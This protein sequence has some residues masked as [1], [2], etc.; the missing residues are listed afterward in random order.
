MYSVVLAIWLDELLALPL[1][2]LA[3]A[4]DVVHAIIVRAPQ[5][6]VHAVPARGTTGCTRSIKLAQG[7]SALMLN[8]HLKLYSH[9][10]R[11]IEPMSSAARCSAA[12]SVTGDAQGIMTTVRQ[13][14]RAAPPAGANSTFMRDVTVAGLTCFDL[15]P[16]RTRCS[17]W[18]IGTAS[19]L[20][21]APHKCLVIRRRCD[22]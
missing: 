5:Q 11:M 10:C 1:C 12:A 14:A 17:L 21:S 18:Y 6:H 13:F 22:V 15:A 2:Q 8:L 7:T 4:D 16:S 3:E 9:W 20:Q 19:T